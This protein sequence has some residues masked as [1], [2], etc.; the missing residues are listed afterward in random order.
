MPPLKLPYNVTGRPSWVG[1]QDKHHGFSPASE[2]T[3][4]PY[5]AA[6]EFIWKHE[7]PQGYLDQIANFIIQNAK[8]V[9]LGTGTSGH[10]DPF[11]GAGRYVPGG[12][13]VSI[14]H[15]GGLGKC[16]H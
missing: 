1:G 10:A 14:V 12:P 8:G 11:T 16:G 4:N 13:G 6:Q 7:I 9:T 2:F 5:Q 15:L 3:E